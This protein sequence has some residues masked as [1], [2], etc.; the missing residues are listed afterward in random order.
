MGEG[1]VRDAR[2]WAV[3]RRNRLPSAADRQPGAIGKAKLANCSRVIFRRKTLTLVQITTSSSAEA[4]WALP[5]PKHGKAPQHANTP[6]FNGLLQDYAEYG[7]LSVANGYNLAGGCRITPPDVTH[8]EEPTECYP[9]TDKARRRQDSAT[10][11]LGGA[12]TACIH[13]MSDG[14]SMAR[15]FGAEIDSRSRSERI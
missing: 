4:P 11:R 7:V 5:C 10:G 1:S 6:N 3:W 9:S 14:S 12:S 8:V 15:G 13:D 2:A